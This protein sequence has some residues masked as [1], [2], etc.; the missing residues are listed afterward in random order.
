ML[1]DTIKKS[2][3]IKHPSGNVMEEIKEAD[4]NKTV[5]GAGVARDSGGVVCTATAECYYGTV[6]KFCC[7]K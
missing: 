6:L 7:P 3:K 4:L 2:N 1:R 5:A